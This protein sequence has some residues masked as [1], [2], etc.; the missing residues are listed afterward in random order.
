MKPLAPSAGWFFAIL[1]P[2]S[3]MTNLAVEVMKRFVISQNSSMRSWRD[4]RNNMVQLSKCSCLL[5]ACTAL[6]A[7]YLFTKALVASTDEYEASEAAVWDW[8][9]TVRCLS[10]KYQLWNWRGATS[11]KGSI[12][13]SIQKVQKRKESKGHPKKDDKFDKAFD[14]ERQIW[15][16]LQRYKSEVGRMYF[17]RDRWGND[18]S[19][20]SVPWRITNGEG[21]VY[22]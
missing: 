21:N 19:T 9:G 18:R 17:L 12:R 11:L 20:K 22:L 3:R 16:W 4:V 14:A 6:Q 13:E 7:V 15:S 2:S 8:N 1:L 5:V 10:R